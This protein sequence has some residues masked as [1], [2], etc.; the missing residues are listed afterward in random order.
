MIVFSYITHPKNTYPIFVPIGARLI[1]LSGLQLFSVRG[2]IPPKE[3]GP[4][5]FMFNHE[6]MFDVLML[7]GAIP[8]YINAVGWEGILK[9]QLI[10][11]KA[12]KY[13]EYKMLTNAKNPIGK[14]DNPKK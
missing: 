5:L 6:S 1:M 14:Q 13:E 12:K 3:D 8:Y 7:G 11:Y 9:I 2:K 10:D 4:Y